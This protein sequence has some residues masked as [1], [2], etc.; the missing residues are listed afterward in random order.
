MYRHPSEN[1]RH[2]TDNL[3]KAIENIQKKKL[4]AIILGDM[5]IDLLKNNQQTNDYKEN[6]MIN[7]F[8]PA[9]TL[10]T[11]ITDTTATLIDHILIKPDS[12]TKIQITAGVILHDISDPH[13]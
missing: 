4:P 5:N 7:N 1:I 12:R 10:P 9:I 11:R 6:I 2:F 13:L 8:I 3:Q